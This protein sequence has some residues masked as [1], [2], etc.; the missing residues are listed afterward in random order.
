MD[1]Q[2]TRLFSPA[3]TPNPFAPAEH[4]RGALGKGPVAGRV[5]SGRAQAGRALSVPVGEGV[6]FGQAARWR[7]RNRGMCN[8]Q[9]MLVAARII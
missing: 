4:L 9:S 6:L 5:R 2:R 1:A 3:E 7:P 8:S